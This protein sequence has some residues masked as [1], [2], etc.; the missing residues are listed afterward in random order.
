MEKIIT[1]LLF[2][3][4]LFSCI[5]ID[6]FNNVNYN[7]SSNIKIDGILIGYTNQSLQ[8]YKLQNDIE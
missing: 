3:S 6:N 1:L 4:L 2:T 5:I 8:E 7:F